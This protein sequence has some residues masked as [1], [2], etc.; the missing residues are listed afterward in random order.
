MT[1]TTHL[2]YL[3]CVAVATVAQCLTGF[4]FGLVLLGLVAMF[5]IASLPEV[6]IAVSVLTCCNA[7]I[8]LKGRTPVIQRQ[9][10]QPLLVASLVG[11]AIGLWVLNQLS[12]DL[13]VWLKLILGSLIFGCSFMLLF[14]TRQQLGF[15]S[16]SSFWISGGLTGL[17]SGLFSSGGPPIVYHLY[18]QP[19]PFDRIKHTLI[20]VF[21][22]NAALRI[23]LVILS[24]HFNTRTAFLTAEALPL[25]LGI[26][27]WLKR[28]P[29]ALPLATIRRMVFALMLI[30]GSSLLVQSLISLSLFAK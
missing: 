10:L 4:A 29:P 23:L 12:G 14:N 13:I 19:L 6:S 27:A 5:Q 3:C 25:V 21:A 26:T 17:L 15:S 30:A 18:R 20:A 24:G 7:A 9:Y 1:P 8:A 16:F 22:A 11:V 28:H 2:L